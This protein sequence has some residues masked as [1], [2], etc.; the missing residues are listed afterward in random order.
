MRTRNSRRLFAGAL[1]LL[2]SLCLTPP[3]V[4]AANASWTGT[5]D[6]LWATPTNWTP[7]TVP[8]T[9]DTAT[10]NGAGNANTTLSL[11]TGVTINSVVFD[12]ASAA[13]YSIGS[14]AVGSQTLLLDATATLTVNSTVTANQTINAALKL[15]PTAGASATTITNASATSLLTLAGPLTGGAGGTAG[16][17]TLT[18]APALNSTMSISGAIGG[19]G[20]TLGVT[21]NGSGTASLS[22]ANTFTGPL[23]MSSGQLSV[24]V[25]NNA[26]T[27]GPLGNSA[28]GVSISFGTLTY[29]GNTAASTK[30]IT[31]SATNAYG[32]V[33]V[34]T[35]GTALTLNGA[36]TGG[37]NFVKDGPGT[38]VFGTS[39]TI[40]SIFI[41]GGT[42]QLGALGTLGSA[43]V[44]L[45]ANAK[46]D[47]NGKSVTVASLSG[48]SSGRVVNNGS[49]T[50]TLTVNQTDFT[51]AGGFLIV[52]SSAPYNGTIADNDGTGGSVALTKIGNGNLALSSPGSYSGATQIQGGSISLSGPA[53]LG[54]ATAGTTVSSGG[55]LLLNDTTNLA[56]PLTLAGA[57]F[58]IPVGA[59]NQV[60]TRGAIEGRGIS[61]L[62]G[63]MTLNASATIFVAQGGN[64]A[65]SNS[66]GG[67]GTV[68]TLLTDYA[69][70]SAAGVGSIGGVVSTGAVTKTG[71][72]AFT[73]SGM[74]T[75]PGVLTIAAGTIAVPVFNNANV[76][77]PL[78]NSGSAV[79]FNQST[80]T[81]TPTLEYSGAT[82]TS[83]KPL[84]ISNS[85]TVQIDSAAA[86]L[87]LSALINGAG[88]LTKAGPGTLTLSVGNTYTGTTISGGSLRLTGS[89]KLGV[90]NGSL[91]IAT[92]ARLDLGG[93]SQIV[94][95]ITAAAGST[96]VNN[97]GG[98]STLT[99]TATGFNSSL[100]GLIADNDNASAGTLSL[101]KAGAGTVFVG[102]PN[103]YTGSTLVSAG[104]LT[105]T[106]ATGLGSSITP[107]TVS[108]GAT[109]ALATPANPAFPKAVTISGVGD[110]ASGRIAALEGSGGTTAS[111]LLT[112]G[113]NATIAATS[114]SFALT[115][116]GTI[117]GSG[118]T[119]TLTGSGTGALASI[120]GTG[121]GAL[122]KTGTGTWILSGANT[123]TGTTTVGAGILNL[124]NDL[125]LGSAIA[126]TS[127]TAG[128]TVQLQGGITVA[129]ES[130][131]INGTGAAGTTGAF[132]NVSG[133]NTWSGPI[134]VGTTTISS[135]AGL[136]NLNSATALT[137]SAFAVP[138][139]L[140]GAGNGAISSVIT[141]PFVG[142]VTKRG[143]GSWTLSGTNTFTG[144]LAVA[145]GTLAVPTVNN[146]S[147]NGPL[148]N[149]STAVTL[150]GSGPTGT[151]EYTGPTAA[152]NAVFSLATG[153]GGAF[154][155]DNP[156]ASLTLSAAISGSGT[157]A[158]S[159][160]GTLILSA[161]NNYTG[162][163]TVSAGTLTL[164]QAVLA[165]AADVNLVTGAT[166][167]LT[168]AGSDTV[169][170]LRI[171]GVVQSAGVWGGPTSSATFKTALISGT[172]TLTV[173]SG[174]TLQPFASWAA[175]NGLIGAGAAF[176]ADPDG[177]GI[178][179]GLEWILGGNPQATNP[180]ILP[181]VSVNA[182]YVVLTF[183]RSDAT[184]VT[185]TLY[186]QWSSDLI[187]WND[188]PVGATS[189]TTP[190]GVIVSVTENAAAPD[191]ISVSF[192]RSLSPSGHLFVRVRATMP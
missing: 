58:S 105:V 95:D 63:P 48:N 158:K 143:T 93:T 19:G 65:I 83:T 62:S 159:G 173:A 116:P 76:A 77:G 90:T 66:V 130:I 21:L 45:T 55:T 35:A 169:N 148:G 124:Q 94:A 37:G 162:S 103:T 153:G 50:A 51:V 11:G 15:G 184:E 9:G 42:L 138:L 101:V 128:A 172:G 96:I 6:S 132:E 8:G 25:F 79:T 127:I 121:A 99:F 82:A 171:D 74:N 156:A 139:T 7:A 136:L 53:T 72:G 61:T 147:T 108:S 110:A 38:L 47:L 30:P 16:A 43:S 41:A 27:N 87:T 67:A 29:T 102:N 22:G 17:K 181:L 89:G 189:I 155:I 185:S 60:I 12:T 26:S 91:S 20:G 163:T 88:G 186:T 71:G 107:I 75:F 191:A 112:L 13:A 145:D 137:G 100:A 57:G 84:T 28:S 81:D 24:P 157:L 118:F 106:N 133:T 69:S 33:S 46:L 120:I 49:G 34:D 32:T 134:I 167:N 117:T 68:L 123:F 4:H 176:T 164:N 177:D 18:L 114:G 54:N 80:G 141:G 190:Q 165:N 2:A 31:F 135:A 52:Q 170:Q 168:F 140:A 179:N 180:G 149:R 97:G 3:W 192:P 131:T 92:G 59:F 109:L 56:E 98:A 182:T 178:P 152:S 188:V 142:A 1:G 78:G 10:F 119:L 175:A 104:T 115:N 129:G 36:I 150:G 122:S 39:N 125:A 64:L 14:G 86:D 44:T 73:L 113:T 23:Q 174:A 111:G 166:L 126:A 151:L 70:S 183:N 5:T 160:P 154:Q 146:A 144:A 85:G 40:G 161:A 187:T